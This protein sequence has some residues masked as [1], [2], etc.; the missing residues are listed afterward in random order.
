MVESEGGGTARLSP[1]ETEAHAAARARELYDA[2]ER[3][4][5]QRDY[6]AAQALYQENQ[7]LFRIP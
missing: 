1:P 6:A 3:A 7:A 5:R 4:F 2:G